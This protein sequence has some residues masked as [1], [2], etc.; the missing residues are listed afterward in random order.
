MTDCIFCKI[1]NGEISSYTVY[2]N[3][4]VKAFLDI[5]PVSP[6]HTLV[7]PKAHAENLAAN[8][9]EDAYA[10][11]AA[12]H[13]LAPKITRAVGASGYNLGMNHGLAA[14][15]DVLHTHLHIMPRRDGQPR[16]FVKTKISSEELAKIS[17][18]ITVEL[19]PAS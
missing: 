4:K 1:V 10:L 12:I 15:Q 17:Q 3:D 8:S 19:T 16:N 9:L 6:G 18:A 14:G 13:D 5:N 11:I 7:I 2:E